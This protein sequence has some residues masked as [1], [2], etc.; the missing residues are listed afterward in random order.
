M[1]NEQ[2]RDI[3]KQVMGSPVRSSAYGIPG[4]KNPMP[5]ACVDDYDLQ[6][7]IHISAATEEQAVS[8]LY[9]D[10]AKRYPFRFAAVELA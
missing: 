2:Q 1:N 3:I 10:L 4:E 7:T 8:M 6:A 5:Y 9:D